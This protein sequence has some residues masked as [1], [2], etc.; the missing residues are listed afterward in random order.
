MCSLEVATCVHE[1]NGHCRA[2]AMQRRAEFRLS[3]LV[4]AEAQNA[5]K[6]FSVCQKE[7]DCTRLWEDD[8]GGKALHIPGKMD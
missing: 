5:S 2:A 7:K 4:P 8:L 6:Y 3:P 1:I